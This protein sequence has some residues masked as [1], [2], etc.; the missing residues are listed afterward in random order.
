MEYLQAIALRK[1]GSRGPITSR[2]ER[3]RRMPSTL[4][5]RSSQL[6]DKPCMSLK[7][8]RISQQSR[9]FTELLAAVQSDNPAEALAAL[10]KEHEGHPYYSDLKAKAKTLL[11]VRSQG[12]K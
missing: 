7:P 4:L 3:T 11:H 2:R 9:L 10:L 6:S 12:K 8:E 1:L 5:Q